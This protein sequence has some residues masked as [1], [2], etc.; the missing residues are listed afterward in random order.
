MV[1]TLCADGARLEGAGCTCLGAH[2]AQGILPSD[3][4]IDAALATDESAEAEL[5][6]E[7]QGEDESAA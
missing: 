1:R 3:T 5:T 2:G 4:T 7:E 6:V